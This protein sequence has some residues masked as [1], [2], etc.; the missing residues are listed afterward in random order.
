MQP[1][2]S[3]LIIG[4]EILSG[5]T[6]DQNLNRLARFLAAHGIALAEARVVGDRHQA[7]INATRALIAEYDMV[8]T[9]GGIGPTH[10]DIT[11]EALAEALELAVIRHPEADQILRDYYAEKGLDYNSARQK[12]ADVPKGA[13][14]I[15][16]PISMAPGYR[17]DNLYALA[18]VP[19]IFAAML[20]ELAP[21]LPQGA[22]KQHISIRTEI[23][24]GTLA[25]GLLAIEQNHPSIS[26]GS[27]PHFTAPR[28]AH[29]SDVTIRGAIGVAVVVSGLDAPAVVAA[30]D[31]VEVWIAECGGTAKRY[32]D[33][34]KH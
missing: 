3:L 29:N 20:E 25:S 22:R 2:A 30:A 1:R 16:N 7:I 11:T 32:G 18:G 17:I 14:L 4:D 34:E 10:D 6:A 5:R 19:E 21:S 15:A 13:E 27:Y 9:C 33:G 8:F 26:I 23:G 12:M 24:E 28:D 31:A